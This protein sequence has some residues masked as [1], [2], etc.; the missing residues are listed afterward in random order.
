[1]VI[2]QIQ[3]L[4]SFSQA[5]APTGVV[6]ARHQAGHAMGLAGQGYFRAVGGHHGVH[7]SARIAGKCA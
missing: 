5:V 1:M 3:Q 2:T 6:W 7:L 4:A